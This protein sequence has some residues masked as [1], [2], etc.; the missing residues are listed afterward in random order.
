MFDRRTGKK[1]VEHVIEIEGKYR[2]SMKIMDEIDP[3]IIRL[4]GDSDSDN[5]AYAESD[6]ELDS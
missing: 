3:M 4:G 2:N 1:C 6:R 5:N